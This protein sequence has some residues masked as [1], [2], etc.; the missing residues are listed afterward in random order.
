MKMMMKN[1]YHRES[2][3]TGAVQT[4]VDSPPINL[5]K[6]KNDLK[7][8]RYYVKISFCRNQTS[9]KPDMYE[10]K[11]ALLDSGEPEELLLSV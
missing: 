11:I 2:W 10:S 1:V 5:V 3:R 9:E 4:Y 7:M 6:S 8:E